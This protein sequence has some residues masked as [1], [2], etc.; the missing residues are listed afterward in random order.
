MNTKRLSQARRLFCR[1]DVPEHVARH[2]IRAWVASVRFLGSKW[3][4]LPEV[5]Q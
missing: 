1:P 5:K 4:A 3:L 2:N